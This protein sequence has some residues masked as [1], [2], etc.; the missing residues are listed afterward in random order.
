MADLD[1]LLAEAEQ[2][3][4][5]PLPF[6]KPGDAD[7]RWD[8]QHLIQQLA[9]A[10]REQRT[11]AETAEQELV[12]TREQALREGYQFGLMRTPFNW[13]DGNP[14]PYTFDI[15]RMIQGE[16]DAR[17]CRVTPAAEVFK[18]LRAATASSQEAEG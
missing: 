2:H 15:E 9:T 7:G 4:N 5:Q 13:P 12:E 14:P 17:E 8:H 16:R 6:S 18:R 10:L 3:W 11:R 1:A